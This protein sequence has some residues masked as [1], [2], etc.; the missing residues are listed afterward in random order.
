[1]KLK[2]FFHIQCVETTH[3][4]PAIE[5]LLP[6]KHRK[7]IFT[8]NLPLCELLWVKKESKPN[9]LSSERCQ[10]GHNFKKRITFHH[11]FGSLTS[12]FSYTRQ[13]NENAG[14]IE[15]FLGSMQEGMLLMWPCPFFYQYTSLTFAD[16]HLKDTVAKKERKTSTQT[17]QLLQEKLFSSG[18]TYIWD[19]WRRLTDS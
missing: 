7:Q 19:T 11:C 8:P 16:I 10:I 3:S 12:W 2:F 14:Q 13:S 18:F 17:A 15:T 5:S 1:M 9:F 6:C 4:I